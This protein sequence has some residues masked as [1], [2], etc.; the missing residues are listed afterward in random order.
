MS[1]TGVFTVISMIS[2]EV[3]KAE[4]PKVPDRLRRNY[5]QY[6]HSASWKRK[7]AAIK[8]RD[9]YTCQVEGCG[10]TDPAKLHCH[11]RSYQY[12]RREPLDHLITVCDRCHGEIHGTIGNVYT[13]SGKYHDTH[14]NSSS[15]YVEDNYERG[16]STET[17]PTL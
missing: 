12:L 8:S 9:G 7:A 3:L 13:K 6:R 15:K 5:D 14:I 2:I 17:V 16:R 1:I 4:N 10:E 11:H